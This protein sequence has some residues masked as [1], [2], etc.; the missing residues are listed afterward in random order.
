MLYFYA[1]Y[2]FIFGACSNGLQSTTIVLNEGNDIL[3]DISRNFNGEISYKANKL[4]DKTQELLEIAE[5]SNFKTPQK[6]ISKSIEESKEVIHSYNELND[7]IDLIIRMK[8]E[9][10]Q[11]EEKY[12]AIKDFKIFLMFINNDIKPLIIKIEQSIDDGMNIRKLVEEYNIVFS[13]INIL[14]QN[15][16]TNTYT[17]S[18]DN[19]LSLI[20]Q[21]Y[22]DG[23]E[24][25][26]QPNAPE[27]KNASKNVDLTKNQ[28]GED[29]DQNN[30]TYYSISNDGKFVV[31]VTKD[32]IV[33]IWNLVEQKLLHTFTGYNNE[34][35]HVV[36]GL[37]GE[38]V[39]I[40]SNDNTSKIWH[41]ENDSIKNAI[42]LHT[43][44]VLHVTFDFQ[45]KYVVTTSDDNDILIWE[46]DS[47]YDEK[48]ILH[49]ET[50]MYLVSSPKY[51]LQGHTDDILDISIS[52]DGKY[53]VTGSNDSTAKIWT[54]EGTLLTTLEG[55]TKGIF[56]VAIVIDDHYIVTASKDNTTILWEYNL[57]TNDPLQSDEDQNKQEIEDTSEQ[58]LSFVV[59]PKSTYSLNNE[60]V[61]KIPHPA[62]KN[63]CTT[64]NR[65][66]KDDIQ[67]YSIVF[68]LPIIITW[69]LLVFIPKIYK[70]NAIKQI[71]DPEIATI[72]GI[73]ISLV[74]GYVVFV[75]C[76]YTTHG[77]IP[78]KFEYVFGT[79]A[80][81]IVLII[82]GL[83]SK[84]S[85]SNT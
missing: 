24:K 7:T 70:R 13:Q 28:L 84:I 44:D 65:C 62:M 72:K 80:L 43:S 22:N 5:K 19:N 49:N 4:S 82:V 61:R 1:F 54:I 45:G 83:R 41:F 58:E 69:I 8:P 6:K 77:Y 25:P 14:Y 60:H 75:S 32:H 3:S 71:K 74:L 15:K 52:I 12:N 78:N 36:F 59:T 57:P 30:I 18:V 33:K 16:I 20:L 37:N 73:T 53:I 39:A 10:L 63:V 81:I 76:A 40:T 48:N 27:S 46:L 66:F 85:S 42:L 11:N 31:I 68:G 23:K 67:T 79:I 29:L 17:K 50:D 56:H 9:E 51:N 55:H 21:K 35:L 2:L 64:G 38:Y 34:I 26:S 47:I